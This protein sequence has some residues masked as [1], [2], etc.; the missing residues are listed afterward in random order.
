MLPFLVH[1]DVYKD[2]LNYDRLVHAMT[3]NITTNYF[4]ILS[5]FTNEY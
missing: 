2:F 1:K 3:V 4:L 5:H